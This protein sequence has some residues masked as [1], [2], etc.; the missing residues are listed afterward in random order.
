MTLTPADTARINLIHGVAD[1][2]AQGDT[3]GNEATA[4][5]Q[6]VCLQEGTSLGVELH[7]ALTRLRLAKEIDEGRRHKSEIVDEI[8]AATPDTANQL[9]DEFRRLNHA[10][11]R[12]RLDLED[13]SQPAA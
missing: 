9:R 10:E 12:L 1:R 13:A 5:Y 4:L 3:L 7:R 2:L 11:A 6:H 8:A